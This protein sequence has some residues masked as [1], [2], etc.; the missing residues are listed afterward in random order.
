MSTEEFRSILAEWVRGLCTYCDFETYC[1][2]TDLPVDHC[3]LQE[4]A[5]EEE[6]FYFPSGTLS[7]GERRVDKQTKLCYWT[8]VNSF[9]Y[10]VSGGTT[11]K[12]YLPPLGYWIRYLYSP[13]CRVFHF[14]ETDFHHIICPSVLWYNNGFVLEWINKLDCS[15][16]RRY[17]QQN[18]KYLPFG[19]QTPE[20][21]AVTLEPRQ[22]FRWQACYICIVHSWWNNL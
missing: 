10:R 22:L 16:G 4:G 13:F 17:L 21:M 2:V 5:K 9:Y 14:I 1:F 20:Q 15:F 11:H 8:G 12:I 18:I 7:G 19:A 3:G 6:L